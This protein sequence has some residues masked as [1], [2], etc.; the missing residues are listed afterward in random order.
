[1]MHYFYYDSIRYIKDEIIYYNSIRYR[2][3][4]LESLIYG[5]N[6]CVA[7]DCPECIARPACIK[8]TYVSYVR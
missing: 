4:K 6:V 5:R 3:G 1:M 7:S 2:C 8:H